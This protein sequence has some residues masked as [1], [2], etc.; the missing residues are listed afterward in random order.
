MK[1]RVLIVDDDEQLLDI[2]AILLETENY[3]AV[4]SVS[5]RETMQ[6]LRENQND[7]FSAVLLDLRLG[8]ESGLELLPK[9]RETDPN[10][11]I[12]MMTA[13]GD[14][15][16]AVAA[17][18]QGA[19]GY[20]KKPFE[21]GQLLQQLNQAVDAYSLK[22]SLKTFSEKRRS[23]ENSEQ[24]ASAVTVRSLIPS[25][26]PL[27][28]Q[29]LER[30][31]TAARVSSS[32]V[33]IGESGTGKEL[34][35]RALHYCGPRREK[36][37]VAFNC[38]AL[39]ETLIESELFGHV[40]GAFTDAKE[41]RS[42]LFVQAQGGTIFLDE[43]GDAPLSIQAKLLRVIQERE[44]LPLGSKSPIKIDVRI[45]AATHRSLVEEMKEGRFRRDLYYRLQV[46]PI[47]VPAL[48]DR[49]KDILYLAHL[50]AAKLS[51]QL[52]MRFDGFSTAALEAL[53]EYPWPGNVRELQNRVEHAL[54]LGRGGWVGKA[55]LFP[56]LGSEPKVFDEPEQKV[57][58]DEIESKSSESDSGIDLST[59]PFQSVDQSLSENVALE[60]DHSSADIVPYRTAPYRTAKDDF[61]KSYWVRLLKEARGNI[62]LAARIAEK[63]RAEIYALLKKHGLHPKLTRQDSAS[64]NQG[65]VIGPGGEPSNEPLNEKGAD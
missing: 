47:E 39:P 60:V 6:A 34:I 2:L 21:E 29:L 52:G 58:V 10:V 56:E 24:E 55:S 13:H 30:V 12:F 65:S 1:N 61:E 48:R 53:E 59:K 9:I 64:F 22:R 18:G 16:S 4:K 42:G 23:R 27:M 8:K 49:K 38:A 35:A 36:P 20:I 32:V 45:V 63:S 3:V 50:F 43:I 26:D 54:A 15:D 19:N 17:F 51:E 33:I 40:K 14:V 28:L 46:I 25:R 11:P 57:H 37:F 5:G 41:N 7:G 44:V 31:G 62:A